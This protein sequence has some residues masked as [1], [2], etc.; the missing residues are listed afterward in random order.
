MPVHINEVELVPERQQRA[1]GAP[2]PAQ[3]ASGSSGDPHAEE[4]AYEVARTAALMHAR[5]LRLRAD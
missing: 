3:Q 4:L 1:A 5:N 2:A